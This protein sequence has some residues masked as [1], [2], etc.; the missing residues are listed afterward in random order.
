MP[1]FSNGRLQDNATIS[2][3]DAFA[4]GARKANLFFG[5]DRRYHVPDESGCS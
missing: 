5:D 2:K 4:I 1:L 3:L